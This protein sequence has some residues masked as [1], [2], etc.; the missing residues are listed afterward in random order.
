MHRRE[1]IFVVRAGRTGLVGHTMFF[2]DEVRA[3]EEHRA[4]ADLVT[5]KELSLAA[6][7]VESLTA[8]FEP[9]K[10]KDTYR[11]NLQSLI[12]AKFKGRN[13]AEAPQAQSRPAEVIDIVKALEKSLAAVKKPAKAEQ[14]A[15][16][17]PKT[18]P[19]SRGGRR[20]A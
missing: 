12:D 6:L 19:R 2:E 15:P 9:S 10:Y 1:H 17:A 18:R 3:G 7:F 20:S 8:P 4:Q 13:I 14:E 16:P 11:E 5:D